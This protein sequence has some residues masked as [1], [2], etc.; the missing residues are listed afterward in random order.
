M[1]T[2]IKVK[3][4]RKIKGVDASVSCVGFVWVR[5][6]DPDRPSKAR[7]LTHHVTGN[8][9]TVCCYPKP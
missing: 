1:T 4:A 3:Q 5:V 7:L 9:V 8:P 6:S 2:S